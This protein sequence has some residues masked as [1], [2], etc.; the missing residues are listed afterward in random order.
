M[1]QQKVFWSSL[2]FILHL[3]DR[4]FSLQDILNSSNHL[5]YPEAVFDEL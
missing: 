5:Q 4:L 1:S 2:T 3:G